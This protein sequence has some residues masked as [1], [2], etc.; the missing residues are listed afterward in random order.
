[1]QQQ[2]YLLNLDVFA[3]R[4]FEYNVEATI[5]VPRERVQQMTHV[6]KFDVPSSYVFQDTVEVTSF[7]VTT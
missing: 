3:S 4:V 5:L 6:H 2:T 7:F 1:M